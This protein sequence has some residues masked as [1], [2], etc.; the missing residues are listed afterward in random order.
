VSG[1]HARG[2]EKFAEVINDDRVIDD[3]RRAGSLGA[4][5]LL[6]AWCQL[7][8][9]APDHPL[10]KACERVEAAAL[11]R[12]ATSHSLTDEV[13]ESATGH[14]QSVE[15]LA[16]VEWL[17]REPGS[18]WMIPAGAR[19]S[20]PNVMRAVIHE[21]A[22]ARRAEQDA[23]LDVPA[24][25][26]AVLILGAVALAAVVLALFDAAGVEW[27][28]IDG[29]TAITG[30]SVFGAAVLRLMG[31]RWLALPRLLSD[32]KQERDLALAQLT[33]LAAILLAGTALLLYVLK[34]SDLKD[35]VVFGVV[36]GVLALV[37][38]GL[39]RMRLAPRW[40][41][42]LLAILSEPRGI[43]QFVRD[44]QTAEQEKSRGA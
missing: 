31:L 35:A 26:T 34:A 25:G 44:R 27:V 43:L 5:E 42:E 10:S 38:L 39:W 9:A 17:G 29:S 22:R 16:L 24:L 20:P 32:R 3:L 37:L 23:R 19:E 4:A 18:T 1:A 28:S 6:T 30:A 7:R 2:L 13:L 41:A 14:D 11:D 12:L 21:V 8:S 36:A 33:I 15:G 40:T